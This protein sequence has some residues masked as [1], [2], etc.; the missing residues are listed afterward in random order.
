MNADSRQ[1]DFCA[2]LSA[3]LFGGLLLNALVGLAVG[4]SGGSVDPSNFSH[5]FVLSFVAG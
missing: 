3:I 2:Y 5:P 4:R 1:A